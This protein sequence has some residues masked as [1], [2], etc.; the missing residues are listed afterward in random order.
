MALALL[1]HLRGGGA[2]GGAIWFFK[3]NPKSPKSG[4]IQPKKIKENPWISFAETSV[5]NELRR[6]P[7]PFSLSLAAP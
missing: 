5:F 4:K 2:Q 1:R 6:P 3:A 7:T